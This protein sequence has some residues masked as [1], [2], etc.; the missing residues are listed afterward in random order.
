MQI[1]KLLVVAFILTQALAQAQ[2]L[3]NTIINH[4]QLIMTEHKDGIV[5][6]NFSEANNPSP[7]CL[8]P[9]NYK[10]GAIILPKDKNGNTA[11]ASCTH[12]TE[13]N[14]KLSFDPSEK[15]ETK[16]YDG[17]FFFN[18][19]EIAEFY[20]CFDGLDIGQGY[21]QNQNCLEKLKNIHALALRK[22]R[23]LNVSSEKL[24]FSHIDHSAR[25]MQKDYQPAYNQMKLGAPMGM[26]V[27]GF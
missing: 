16:K 27:F 21:N 26:Q 5:K 11:P 25:H 10:N 23:K 20:S 3:E 6:L 4:G 12:V 7:Y 1:K 8:I 19:T 15:F 18:Q 13:E 14:K 9:F 24:Y 17:V 22:K 2:I